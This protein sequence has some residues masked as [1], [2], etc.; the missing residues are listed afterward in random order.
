M[1]TAWCRWRRS[2]AGGSR[3]SNSTRSR[4]WSL[5]RALLAAVLPDAGGQAGHRAAAARGHRS[6]RGQPGA[7]SAEP[8]LPVPGDHATAAPAA[9]G[10]RHP[11]LD[12]ADFRT[13]VAAATRWSTWRYSCDISPTLAIGARIGGRLRRSATLTILKATMAQHF[14]LSAAA[15]TGF[16]PRPA[17]GGRGG[18]GDGCA[19]PFVAAGT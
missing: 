5:R 10:S 12:R 3:A 17:G 6:L 11:D 9:A 16:W 2:R 1:R 15:R 13:Y 18:G 14:R 8:A 7:L 19:G 4:T